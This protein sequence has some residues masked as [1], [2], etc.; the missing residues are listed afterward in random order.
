MHRSNSHFGSVD[1]RCGGR[2]SHLREGQRL[3]HELGSAPLPI[4]A[5]CVCSGV[6]D[7]A[8]TEASC[9]LIESLNSPLAPRHAGS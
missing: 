4:D 8:D 5:V 3:E 2:P 9:V 6:C 1:S 7:E